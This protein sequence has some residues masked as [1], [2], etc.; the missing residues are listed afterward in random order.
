ML[1]LLFYVGNSRFA[2][3]SEYIVEI[4]P[5][6]D[7]KQIPHAPSYLPGLLNYGG[8]PVPVIDTVRLI[9][10]RSSGNS[11]HTRI[12][13]LKH[14]SF[15]KINYLAL[16]CEKAVTAVDLEMSQFVST[17]L[18]SEEQPYLGGIYT[19]GLDTIQYFDIPVLVEWL[20]NVLMVI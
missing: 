11:M 12:V 3:N 14:P 16:I 18:R 15:E 5:K 2:L 1:M 13:L 8:I 6:V 4:V 20:K 17:G 9:E 10:D 19:E 7:L